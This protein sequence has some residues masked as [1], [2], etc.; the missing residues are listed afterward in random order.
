MTK[1]YF[2][3]NRISRDIECKLHNSI[4]IFDNDNL[5]L[6]MIFKHWRNSSMK[7]YDKLFRTS[8]DNYTLFFI[9]M[10]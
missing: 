2:F 8:Y 4:E 1:L 7:L 3:S 10:V 5:R 9:R 6:K